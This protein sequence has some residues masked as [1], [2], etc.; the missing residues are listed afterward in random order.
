MVKRTGSM[1]E[2]PDNTDVL[3]LGRLLL[4]VSAM[5][6]L[7]GYS[8]IATFLSAFAGFFLRDSTRTVSTKPLE[9]WLVLSFL[10]FCVSLMSW[11]FLSRGTFST[12]DG[13]QNYKIWF[14]G[15]F[16]QKVMGLGI[17]YHL[18][19]DF[20]TQTATV[21]AVRFLEVRVSIL[22]GRDLVAKDKNIWGR[23]VSSDPYVKV[24]HGPNKVG[25]TSIVKKALDPKWAETFSINVLPRTLD[26]YKTIECNIY[27]HDK[28]SADDSMGTCHVMIPTA[29]NEKTVD[30]YPVEKG[31]GL[32]FCRN[33]SGMLKIEVELRSK[34]GKAFRSELRSTAESQRLLMESESQK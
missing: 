33:A 30:W 23:K 1:F 2:V 17:V 14:V 11:I 27:D 29:L 28:L 7:W 34:L 4:T 22:E 12:P 18:H 15:A 16:L 6:L 32:N 25:K 26:V 10:C 31:E 13:L 20:R 24:Y 3:F 19:Q 9:K 21:E 5:S 8:S